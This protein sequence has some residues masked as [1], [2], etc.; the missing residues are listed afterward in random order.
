MM[1]SRRPCFHGFSRTVSYI[2]FYCFVGKI[3]V[4]EKDAF[5]TV[6]I[7]RQCKLLEMVAPKN[8]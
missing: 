4:R 6:T 5:F 1:L 2:S 7:L 8:L 3:V